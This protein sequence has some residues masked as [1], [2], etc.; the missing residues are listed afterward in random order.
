MNSQGFRSAG[1]L[2]SEDLGRLISAPLDTRV[3]F[4]SGRLI[5]VDHRH[6]LVS[7][8]RLCEV[9]EQFAPSRSVEVLIEGWLLPIALSPADGVILRDQW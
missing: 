4:P 7:D 2:T 9:E 5:G 8:K 3:P 1:S 6:F